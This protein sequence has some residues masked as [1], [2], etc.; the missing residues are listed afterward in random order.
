[1]LIFGGNYIRKE[2]CVSEWGGL[3][4]GRGYIQEAFSR[5]FTLFCLQYVDFKDFPI[6]YHD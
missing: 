4:L 6:F 5:D 2:L 3:Y 1:M